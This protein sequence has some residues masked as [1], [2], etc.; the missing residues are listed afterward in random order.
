MPN[1][2][3]RELGTRQARIVPVDGAAAGTHAF[4]LGYDLPQHT[5]TLNVGDYAQVEQAITFEPTT[6]TLE[7]TVDVREP[8]A[9][10]AGLVWRAALLVDG[11][12]LALHELR[13]GARK[14]RR[15]LAANVSKAAAGAHTVA[16]RLRLENA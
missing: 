11:T 6:K 3:N 8:A 9:M 16:V 14:R 2:F 12:V 15:V 7:I 10:P 1:A 4:C 5:E 13:G